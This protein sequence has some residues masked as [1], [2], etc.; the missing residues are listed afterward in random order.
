MPGPDFFLRIAPQAVF[1]VAG[2]AVVAG[3]DGGVRVVDEHGLDSG[4]AEFDAQT[5]LASADFLG[6]QRDA[7]VKSLLLRHSF[8]LLASERLTTTLSTEC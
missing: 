3:C 2:P 7:I 5:R 6:G 1:Q 4:G 8:K